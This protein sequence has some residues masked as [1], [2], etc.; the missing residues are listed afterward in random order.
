MFIRSN[1]TMG[2]QAH[3]YAFGLTMLLAFGTIAIILL[4]FGAIW[5]LFQAA[6][7]LIGGSIEMLSELGAV[8]QSA[9]PL[10]KTI[11]LLAF[12]YGLYRVLRHSRGK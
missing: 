12:S 7:I 5:L 2:Q 9:D 8:F 4:F 3:I 1:L 6:F 11:L 10:V